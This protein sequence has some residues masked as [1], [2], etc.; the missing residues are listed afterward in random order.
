MKMDKADTPKDTRRDDKIRGW[1]KWKKY[2][3][4]PLEVKV[5]RWRSID[6]ISCSELGISPVGLWNIGN[7]EKGPCDF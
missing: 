7:K 2:L 5:A 3:K 4:W 1:Y 6:E